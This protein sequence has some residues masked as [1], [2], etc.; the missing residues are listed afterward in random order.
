MS[1]VQFLNRLLVYKQLQK[2]KID[3]KKTINIF[4]NLIQVLTSMPEDS[5]REFK[6]IFNNT[7]VIQ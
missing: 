6:L 2:E 3:L 1:W 5:E 7:Q 4:E